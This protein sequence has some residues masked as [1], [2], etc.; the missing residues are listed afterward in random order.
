VADRQLRIFPFEMAA[1][2]GLI[3]A[4]VFLRLH[5]LRIDW[6]T[7][8]YTV[9]PLIPVMG[10]FLVGGILIYLVYLLLRRR[11]IRPYLK[12]LATWRWWILTARLWAAIIVFT[13]TY[14]WLKVC[15]PL[16]NERLWDQE[17]WR[18]DALVHL[19]FSPS[20]FLV[21][22][23]QGT[24]LAGWLDTWYGIWLP[25]V[26]F[27]I[28]FFCA[29]PAAKFRRRFVLSCVLIWTLGAW[30]YVAVPAL[31]PIY[32]HNE[33]FEEIVPQLPK[34]DAG[35]G[36][37]WDNYQ[38]VIA[39]RIGGLKQFNPTRGIAALPSLHVG[40]HWLLMLWCRRFARPL[41]VPALIGTLLTL[42]GSIVTG[43]HYAVDGYVG[44]ALAQL[45]YWV[46]NLTE[47][48]AKRVDES[49]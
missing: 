9:P 42:L 22:L 30:M 27:G 49:L 28:A 3:A 39:G 14:F 41:F 32:A 45:S 38:T 12:R 1:W 4:V 15:V 11:S 34:A 6:V 23:T 2:V 5:N 13:Y 16:V 18:L 24:V 10:R 7:F 36:L 37:L 26:S 29:I 44:I 31:G 46:S 21:E 47:R 35:Q 17:L 33:V 25:S 40:A 19:G 8:E 20:V 48:P 43:W